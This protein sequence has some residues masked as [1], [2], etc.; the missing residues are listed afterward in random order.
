MKIKELGEFA[1]IDLIK[2]DCIVEPDSVVVG[3]GD[4]AA[5]L[6]PT[7][8]M[9]QLVSTD[10]LVEGVHFDLSFILPFQLGY[11]SLAVNLSDIAAMGGIPKHVVI[12]LALPKEIDLAF[13]TELYRGMKAIAKEFRVNIVGGDT[14]STNDKIVINVTVLGE[15]EPSRLQKRSGAQVGDLVVVTNQLGSSAA[16]LD[17]FL[18]GKQAE[19]LFA[20]SLCRAHLMPIPQVNSAQAIAKYAHSMNDI[21]DGLASEAKEIAVASKVNVILYED[22]IPLLPETIQT[23]KYF[24]KIPSEYALFGGE[25]YQLVFTIDKK[26][27]QILKNE[28]KDCPIAV[29]GEIIEGSGEVVLR[30]TSEEFVNLEPKGYNHFR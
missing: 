29:V 22:K 9:L 5:V 12:S 10:M 17:I 27:Y 23:A 15:V 25:D 30:T 11:K 1:C 8:G 28:L 18:H 4:D 7:Q 19:L 2:E 20:K 16:G 26:Q 14:V 21:S 24:D 13:V 6:Q 3:I